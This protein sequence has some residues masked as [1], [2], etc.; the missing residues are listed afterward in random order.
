MSR[1]FCCNS[2][3]GYSNPVVKGGEGFRRDNEGSFG[4]V[5]MR[6]GAKGSNGEPGVSF[7]GP[8]Q[9]K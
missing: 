9:L 8:H 7:S 1:E 6:V 2:S 3:V 4:F 5:S